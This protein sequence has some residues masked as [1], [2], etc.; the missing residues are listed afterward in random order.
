MRFRMLTLGLCLAAGITGTPTTARAAVDLS[1]EFTSLTV[2]GDSLVDAGNVYIAT[3]GAIPPASAGY[4]Q[5]RF[6]N[7]YVYTDVLSIDLFGTPTVPYLAGGT[8]FAVG[9]AQALSNLD[10][11][12]DLHHQLAI[13][14]TSGQSIDPTG[15]YIL[16]F[17]GNDVRAALAPGIP[18]GFASDEAFLSAA[19]LSYA[20]GVQALASLGAQNLLVTGFPVPG[21]YSAFAESQ[22]LAQLTNL[23]LAPDTN[24]YFY[25]YLDFYQRLIADPTAFGFPSTLN[26]T[27]SCQ[28]AQALPDC[29]GFLYFDNIHPTAAIHQAAYLDMKREFGFTASAPVPEPATWLMLILGFGA[30]GLALRAGKRTRTLSLASAAA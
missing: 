7:G 24:L 18:T 12:P 15:L 2:F 26:T 14:S 25:S 16:N 4:F 23:Q 13:F 20:A 28:A 8:N 27:T 29:A 10:P 30:V 6:T 11:S 17:G 3:A 5:G 22:F 21:D 19:A 1:P 9:G